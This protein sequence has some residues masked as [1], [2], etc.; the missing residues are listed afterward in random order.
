VAELKR[1]VMSPH[2]ESGHIGLIGLLA[3]TTPLIGVGPVLDLIHDEARDYTDEEA[4]SLVIALDRMS[5]ICQAAA[6]TGE[7]DEPFTGDAGEVVE[8]LRERDPRAL[9][10]SMVRTRGRRA[11]EAALWSWRTTQLL[12]GAPAEVRALHG[13]YS[14]SDLARAHLMK[15]VLRQLVDAGNTSEPERRREAI[16]DIA[17]LLKAW[18]GIS[19]GVTPDA[20]VPERLR[21]LSFTADDEED[22]LGELREL[23]LSPDSAEVRPELIAALRGTAPEHSVYPLL[24]LLIDHT[25]A[26]TDEELRELLEALDE[27]LQVL[28]LPEAHK[29]SCQASHVALVVWMSDRGQFSASSRTGP[30]SK[31]PRLPARWQRRS[32]S[33]PRSS[34]REV[35][36]RELSD[37]WN[38]HKGH[39]TRLRE[40][41]SA[42]DL[43]CPGV[44][45]RSTLENE[46]GDG[47]L[48]Q[49]R[50]G[51]LCPWRPSFA[52]TP[53]RGRRGRGLPKGS[54][55]PRLSARLR[56]SQRYS[57]PGNAE[58]QEKGASPNPSRAGWSPA[59]A[60]GTVLRP[61]TTGG[62]GPG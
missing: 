18:S 59:R 9:L 48:R 55:N 51:T 24:D 47:G 60:T 31:S 33:P 57:V 30:T 42:I 23:L 13:D 50:D 38:H 44:A 15:P 26:L 25:T 35:A 22:L 28:R 27:S 19:P 39:I 21:G 8:R 7:D 62:S 5:D 1:L 45:V 29:D 36:R 10:T 43:P 20:L 41:S 58:V 11:A 56:A 12:L 40:P 53:G 6:R 16:S 37:T 49:R 14:S 2:S 34:A 32:S 17:L 54:P 52:R 3:M 46:G 4:R 61:R